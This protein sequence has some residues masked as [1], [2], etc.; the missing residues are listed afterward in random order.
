MNKEKEI[1]SNAYTNFTQ[2]MKIKEDKQEEKKVKMNFLNGFFNKQEKVK[3]KDLFYDIFSTKKDS[4][5]EVKVEGDLVKYYESE[6]EENDEI[7]S[8]PFLNDD[9]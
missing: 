7:V 9:L 1:F 5:N 4:R 3:P 2:D 6:F 8:H